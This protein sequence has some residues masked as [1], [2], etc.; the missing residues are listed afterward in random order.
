M[1]EIELT[2]NKVSLVDDEDYEAIRQL[3]W[4]ANWNGWKWYAHNRTNS[5]SMHRFILRAKRG[6]QIDHKNGNGLD[7]RKQNLRF[8]TNQQNAFNQ[9]Y[10]QKGNKLGLKG[11]YWHRPM[12]KFTAEITVG[13]KHMHLGFFDTPFDADTVY[14]EAEKTYFGEFARVEDITLS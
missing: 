1:K 5:I 11:V 4:Y 9:K 7:N 3:R 6:T 13:G 14:R 12:K 8:C 2:R 10:P